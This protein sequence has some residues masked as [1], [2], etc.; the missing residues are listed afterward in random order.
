MHVT[1]RMMRPNVS[2][3]GSNATETARPN[4]S[5][6]GYDASWKAAAAKFKRTHPFCLGCEALNRRVATEVVDH[7]VPHKGDAEV[8]W[9]A[10]AWQPA[11]R[12]H[13]AVVKQKLERLFLQGT[14]AAEALWLDSGAAVSIS[15]REGHGG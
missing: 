13:H 2:T 8:F 12:W 3:F 4:A 9:N 15:I 6:R 1:I 11:C 14:I 5:G 10:S 7:V